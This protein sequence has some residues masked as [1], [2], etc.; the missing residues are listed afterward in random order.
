MCLTIHCSHNVFREQD[1]NNRIKSVIDVKLPDEQA[2]FR[3]NRSCCDQILAQT[4]HIELGFE[5]CEKTAAVFID[6]SSAYMIPY[7]GMDSC[8][9]SKRSGAMHSYL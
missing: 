9:N 8:T 7:G 2:G 4:T 1:L 5:K 6:L 3:E